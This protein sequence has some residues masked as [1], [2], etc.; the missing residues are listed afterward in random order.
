MY[1]RLIVDLKLKNFFHLVKMSY[2]IYSIESHDPSVSETYTGI[3]R[4]LDLTE[5]YH[6]ECS[7]EGHSYLYE[8]IRSHGGWK[9]FFVKQLTSH[10]TIEDARDKKIPGKLNIYDLSNPRVPTIYKIF[11]RDPQ[12]T[13]LYVG[14]SINYDHRKFAHFLSSTIHENKNKLYE[15]IRSHG[16]WKNWKMSVI[17]Q[18]PMSTT[19]HELD[20]REWYW[21]NTLGGELNS[22]IPGTHKSKWK[23]SDEEFE[24]SVSIDVSRK[25]FFIKEITLD[26]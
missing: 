9:N 13:Q 8:F 10:E 11:C 19:N 4:D 23:G 16:G 26:I 18:Y 6:S 14:Q 20:R 1:D 25:N 2:H 3:T 5:F 12:V 17:K 21:W 7:E 24:Y 15:F 22:M